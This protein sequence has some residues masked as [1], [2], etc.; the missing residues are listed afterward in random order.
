MVLRFMKAQAITRSIFRAEHRVA[1]R[2][3]LEKV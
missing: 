3:V 2:S 1:N